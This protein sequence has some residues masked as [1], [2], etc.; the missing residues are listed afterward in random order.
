ML[1]ANGNKGFISRREGKMNGESGILNAPLFPAKIKK[2]KVLKIETVEITEIEVSESR[3]LKI[4]S[5]FERLKKNLQKRS[6]NI[7]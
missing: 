1:S 3:N 6:R 7:L 2:E 4:R 5:R